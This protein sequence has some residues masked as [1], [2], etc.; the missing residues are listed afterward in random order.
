[1]LEA[2]EPGNSDSF[3]RAFDWLLAREITEVRGDWAW[4]RADAPIGG[5]PFQYNNAHYPDVDDSAVVVMAMARAGSAGSNPAQERAAKWIIALPTRNGGLGA[6][7][8]GQPFRDLTPHPP[9][10]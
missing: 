6:F 5:W 3:T 2:G 1:M 10:P 7:D 8:P 9:H 4:R